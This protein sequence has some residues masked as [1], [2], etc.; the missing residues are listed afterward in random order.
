MSITPPNIVRGSGI[1]T[2]EQ[3]AEE[4]RKARIAAELR[5]QEELRRQALAQQK[6]RRGTSRR[7]KRAAEEA[8][9]AAAKERKKQQREEDFQISIGAFKEAKAKGEKEGIDVTSAKVKIRRDTGE[10]TISAKGTPTAKA[11]R[12]AQRDAETETAFETFR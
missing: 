4:E 5:R 12:Q 11:R 6:R 3:L 2:R 7:A 1:V 9:E 10:V 8:S